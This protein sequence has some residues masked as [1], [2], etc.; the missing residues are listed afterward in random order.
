MQK[1]NPE[2][3]VTDD[4]SIFSFFDENRNI[5]INY[6]NKLAQEI[7]KD[8]CLHLNPIIVNNDHKVI[9]GQNRLE[10][11]KLISC[12][13]YYIIDDT[14]NPERLI[15][16]NTQRKNW[17]LDDF[18]NYW[19]YRS[20][21]NY[22][23]FYNFMIELGWRTDV[24][25]RW[26]STNRGNKRLEFKNG[27]FV[28]DL[29]NKLRN[30]ICYAQKTINTIRTNFPRHATARFRCEFHDALR[31]FLTYEYIDKEEFLKKIQESGASFRLFGDKEGYLEY[32]CL[33]YN[34]NKR[35][36]RIKIVK[37]KKISLSL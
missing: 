26:L 32:F 7:K 31:E 12:S 2:V 34:H 17:C 37:D 13:I 1:K 5:K 20:P 29:D 18:L 3:H 16:L 25:I 27:S 23:K 14:Y 9:D 30:V 15:R 19:M 36:N 11:A 35:I 6:V 28:F 21:E 24:L 8:N 10:A 22:N 4:L 33:V